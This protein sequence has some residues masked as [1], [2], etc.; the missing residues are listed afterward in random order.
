MSAGPELEAEKA[1]KHEIA[2]SNLPLW[3]ALMNVQRGRLR[4]NIFFANWTGQNLDSGD[5]WSPRISYL[6]SYVYSGNAWGAKK[7]AGPVILLSN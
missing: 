4:V 1:E 6:H 5:G 7:P 2:L 3:M